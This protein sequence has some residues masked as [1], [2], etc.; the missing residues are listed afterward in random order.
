MA[1]LLIVHSGTIKSF[2]NTKYYER[3][4]DVIFQEIDD[5][6][7]LH[8]SN[9][10][11][12]DELFF[13]KR[14]RVEN[15][16]HYIISKGYNFNIWAYARIDTVIINLLPLLKKAGFNWLALGIE[17]GNEKIRKTA[18]K[19]EFTNNDIRLIVRIIKDNGIYV[20]GNFIFGFID[21]D[22]NSMIETREFSRELQ[23]E[24]NNLYSMMAY[25]GSKLY[26]IAIK[27]NWNLPETWSGYSQYSY[28]CH[29]VRTNFL[30]S[31]EVLKFRDE[32]FL[33]IYADENYQEYLK[34][35]FGNGAIVE[36]QNI[37]KI[38]LKRKLLEV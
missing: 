9:I 30:T 22:E 28:E 21:D 23:C 2:Y 31:A 20:C 12:L 25:P 37:L 8:V 34:Q 36:V 6:A 32:S 27:H 13:F 29:P 33:S 10:K 7:N 3:P 11:I 1:V 5:F 26:Q 18:M 24:F 15:I 17:S 19:G 35:T 4:L 16:C 38:N 14:N